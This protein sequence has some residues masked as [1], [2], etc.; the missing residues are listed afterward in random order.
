MATRCASQRRPDQDSRKWR[1]ESV[2]SVH[3][4]LTLTV[5]LYS[6]YST[7]YYPAGHP[8]HGDPDPSSSSFSRMGA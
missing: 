6:M 4:V 2:G 5:V 7:R 8:R 1:S 3:T